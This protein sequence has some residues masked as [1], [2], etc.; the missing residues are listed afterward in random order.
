[1]NT[2]TNTAVACD[3]TTNCATCTN[4]DAAQCTACNTDFTLANGICFADAVIAA[5]QLDS[6]VVITLSFDSNL[7]NYN[8]LGGDNYFASQLAALLGVEVYQIKIVS[9][10]QGSVVIIF[11]VFSVAGSGV[12]AADLQSQILS[13][14]ADG[15][16]NGIYGTQIKGYGSS[17][18]SLTGCTDGFYLDEL[19]VCQAC[20]DGCDTCTS[21]DEKCGTN[22]GAIVGG[23]I[24]G[25][26]LIVII[27]IIYLKRESIKKMVSPKSYNKV[28]STPTNVAQKA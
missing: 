17:I 8:E 15:G 28:A 23:V 7:V 4:S 9:A 12:T 6:G 25:V 24:G 18:M 19:S 16:L 10:K 2:V 13:A 1:L 21:G 14:Y 26:A 20:P 3:D 5:A 11:K 22:V 27:V